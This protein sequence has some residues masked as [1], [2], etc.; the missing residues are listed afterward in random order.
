MTTCFYIILSLSESY[1][2]YLYHIQRLL[3]SFFISNIEH[4]NIY[5]ILIFFLMG[6]MTS[7]TPCLISTV[8][9]SIAY[10]K[11]FKQGK[12]Y[13][14]IFLF[15]L[16]SSTLLIMF[17]LNIFN[18]QYLYYWNHLPILSSIILCIVSLNMLQIFDLSSFFLYFNRQWISLGKSND[19]LLYN[20][21]T[22]FTIGF[23]V[24]PCS[25][26][27][28]FIVSFWLFNSI[29]ILFTVCYFF[30]YSIGYLISI[31][32][33]FNF[34]LNYINLTFISYIWELL[35]PITGCIIL[36]ISLLNLLEQLFI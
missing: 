36:I 32:F 5:S 9:L 7:L 13:K 4:F 6:V 33:I 20:Y 18:Y 26:P 16:I 28:I 24:L 30:I 19:I 15:G 25:S 17:L 27:I 2:V 34:A 14:N 3:Y 22:G 35:I 31:L 23:S 12:V 8:P 10:I 11:S 1:Q 21:L 29:N